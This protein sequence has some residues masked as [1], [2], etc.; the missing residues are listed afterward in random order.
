MRRR[1][2]WALGLAVVLVLVAAP[3]AFGEYRGSDLLGNVSPQSQVAGG[4][5]DHYPLSAYGLDYHVDVGVTDPGGVPAMIAQWAAAQLWSLA[6]FLVKTVIDLFTWAFSLDLLGGASGALGPIAQAITSLYDNVIGQAWMIAAILIAGI[7]GMWKALVQRRYTETVGGLALSVVFVVVALFF[8]YQPERTIGEASRW[9]NTLSLAF[10]SG[11]NRGSLDN[12]QQAKRQVADHLF[13]T[14]VFR[15]WVVLE[16]GGLSH[17]VDTHRLDSGGFPHPVGPHDPTA[18]VCRDHV[19][20]DANGF[21]GYAPLFLRWP[22]GSTQR[23]QIY[24]ALRDGKGPDQLQQ[25]IQRGSP[26]PAG[27][28]IDKAD[29]PAVD[30][31]QAGGAFQRLT[32]AVVVLLGSLGAVVLL[33]FLSLAVI[34]A[35]VVAL[36]L[37]GFAPVALVIGVF[38]GAGHEFFRRWLARLATAV[39]IKALYSLVLAIVV[40]VSAALAS[41]AG[42]LGFLFAFGLQT[43]FFWAIFLYRKQLTARLVSATTGAGRLPRTT[44]IQKGTRAATRPVTALVGVSRGAWQRDGQRQ[45]SALAGGE[46]AGA[47]ATGTEGGTATQAPAPST[48][49]HASANGNGNGH[50]SAVA[51]PVRA[52][53]SAAGLAERPPSSS[54]G[55]GTAAWGAVRSPAERPPE[56]TPRAAHED[57]LRRA[58]ELRE[59]QRA[60]GLGDGERGG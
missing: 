11:A 35:Q 39:F 60:M 52:N 9:T 49:G 8:V 19:R 16:F 44:V 26:I 36:V 50:G 29:A 51:A 27:Q 15:P 21:G 59:H 6:S 48:N 13:E 34:L 56:P 46:P 12:P 38:P 22:A 40:A 1:A 58:R 17:C 10:L 4:L 3:L 7:W 41:S 28:R 33:G 14:L 43:I 32:F 45:E 30:I 57:V 55:H 53:G 20:R 23:G 18:N 5:M 42:S 54:N 37:L 25:S 31:Q 2:A 47:P 24:A